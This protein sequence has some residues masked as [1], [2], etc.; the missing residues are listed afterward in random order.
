M[1]VSASRVEG[2][3]VCTVNL[4]RETSL[5]QTSN[6]LGRTGKGVLSPLILRSPKFTWKLN[7]LLVGLVQSAVE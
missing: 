2:L 4:V 6:F 5:I 7:S 1:S 3:K